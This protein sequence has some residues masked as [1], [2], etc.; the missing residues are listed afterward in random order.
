MRQR[1][2]LFAVIF[3]SFM[4]VATPVARPSTRTCTSTSTFTFDYP[5]AME[6]FA[7]GIN[8]AG[9]V[10]GYYQDLSGLLHGFVHQ[11][12]NFISTGYTTFDVP[13]GSLLTEAKGINDAGDIVGL[14]IDPS[15]N[16]RGFVHRGTD[17][18]TGYQT[19]DVPSQAFFSTSANGINQSGDIV[20][21]YF[22]GTTVHGFL[23]HGTDFS[24]GYTTVDV[25]GATATVLNGINSQ[26]DPVGLYTDTKGVSHGFMIHGGTVTTLDPPS[27]T[28]PTPLPNGATELLGI[29]VHQ[30]FVGWYWATGFQLDA[31]DGQGSTFQPVTVTGSTSTVA[32][33]INDNGQIVGFA[34]VNNAFHGFFAG[35]SLASGGSSNGRHNGEYEEDDDQG[36]GCGH[37]G[38]QGDQGGDRD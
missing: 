37:H 14:Y 17:F 33:G 12:S 18:S 16:V 15:G 38:G 13:G 5:G 30:A 2:M 10:G 31:F 9:A 24:T 20:G 22:A 34:M 23:H 28:V 1:T 25:P 8:T 27:T 19:I 7:T 11:G 35:A 6:T 4:L 26:G 21:Q 32:W 29:N 3:L 36:S